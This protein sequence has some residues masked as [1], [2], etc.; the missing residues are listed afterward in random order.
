MPREIEEIA[1]AIDGEH[2]ACRQPME[3]HGEQQDQQQ[4]QP[5]RRDRNADQN[6]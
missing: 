6:E 5:K 4:T 2:P 3:P 1:A